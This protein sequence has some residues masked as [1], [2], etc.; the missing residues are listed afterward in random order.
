MRCPITSSTVAQAW[1]EERARL[2]RVPETLPE[3]FDLVATR[4]VGRDGLVSFEGRQYVSAQISAPF[5]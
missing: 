3:P 5:H 1:A 2:T 4:Q